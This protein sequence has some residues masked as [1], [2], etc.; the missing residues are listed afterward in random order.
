[1]KR[2]ESEI[3]LYIR[4]TEIDI[5]TY[6]VK[7]LISANLFTQGGGKVYSLG[8]NISFV[9]LIANYEA[10]WNDKDAWPRQTIDNHRLGNDTSFLRKIY[11]K[12][13]HFFHYKI[14]YTSRKNY[15]IFQITY[16]TKRNSNRIQSNKNLAFNYIKIN[17]K[18]NRKI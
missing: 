12:S 1:M 9:N 14:V 18:F 10:R 8:I 11:W 17:W 3:P 6:L 4:I 13:I 7:L 16:N 15:L 2:F 5:T